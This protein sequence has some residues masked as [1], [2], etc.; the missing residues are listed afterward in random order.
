MTRSRIL[1]RREQLHADL[2]SK[3]FVWTE[4]ADIGGTIDE[5]AVFAGAHGASIVRAFGDRSNPTLLLS[6][7][8][9]TTIT[10]TLRYGRRPRLTSM[11]RH[12]TSAGIAIGSLVLTGLVVGAVRQLGLPHAVNIALGALPLAMV[13]CAI[14]LPLVPAFGD[15]TS[16]MTR[17]L[18]EFNGRPRVTVVAQ[19]YVLDRLVYGDVAAELGYTFVSSQNAWRT[20]SR[21]NRAWITFLKNPSQQHFGTTSNAGE[22]R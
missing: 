17:L 10:D 21:W 9:V 20:N 7:V 11:A 2:T 1:R 8:P 15:T 18:S 5:V 22:R 4:L 12:W 14:A 19:Q 3:P 13:C 6:K 16:R